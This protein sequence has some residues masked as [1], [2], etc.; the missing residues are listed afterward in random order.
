MSN[1]IN[2]GYGMQEMS[3]W[4]SARPF[5]F[6]KTR[7]VIKSTDTDN[8]NRVRDMLKVDDDGENR[9]FTTVTAAIAATQRKK[10]LSCGTQG[11]MTPTAPWSVTG[12]GS[13]L[14]YIARTW[15]RPATSTRY[16]PWKI[17]LPTGTP[18]PTSGLLKLCGC[19]R[20]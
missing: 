14:R 1:N 12:T 3:A 19:G 2:A 18:W 16:S 9:L 17:A 5:A 11:L 4:V 7:F 8:Y 6:G 15:P 20:R 10:Q 13:R